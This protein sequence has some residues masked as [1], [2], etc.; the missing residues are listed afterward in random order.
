MEASSQTHQWE[1]P[2]S[3]GLYPCLWKGHMEAFCGEGKRAD[4]SCPHLGIQCVLLI[5]KFLES[6]IGR[7]G[8]AILI[9]NPKPGPP[10]ASMVLP[11]RC[12]SVAH[13]H[14]WEAPGGQG[15]VLVLHSLRATIYV[16]SLAVSQ[17]CWCEK[18]PHPSLEALQVPFGCR[19]S[20]GRWCW[21]RSIGGLLL[22]A[23]PFH[24]VLVSSLW[25][26]WGPASCSQWS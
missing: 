23:Q 3:Q 25:T 14:L 18:C 26:G 24:Q 11:F 4:I 1:E 8:G 17:P 16:P 19:R 6:R 9:W 15:H 7:N 5:K 10:Q 22:E 12:P 13:W 20:Y 21:S 2:C